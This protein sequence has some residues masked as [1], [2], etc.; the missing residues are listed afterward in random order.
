MAP[1]PGDSAKGMAGS[2]AQPPIA[3]RTDFNPLAT[4]AAEVR[5]GA[6]GTAQVAIE[7]PDNLT[8]YR[9]MVVAVSGGT[10]FGTAEANLVARLPLMVRPSAPRFLN[11]GD[12]FEFPVVLQNQT[13]EPMAVDVALR[14]TNL[15]L[16][17]QPGPAPHRPRPRPARGALPSDHPQGRHGP[18]PG[19]RRLGRLCRR[20]IRRVPRLHPGHDRGLCHLRRRRRG[21]RRP[22]RGGR[23]RFRL[24]AVRRPGDYHL[25]HRAPGPHRRRPLP[26][27][28]PLRVLRAV[29]V[30][31]PGRLGPA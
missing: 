26:R 4:F 20:G 24:L 28:L 13:D 3:V 21:R 2:E 11:F 1:A 16:D 7:L 14:V 10:H 29:G 19:S 18:L 23:R 22:A 17:R 9:V 27:L 6:G 12:R 15:A 8:R 31:H 5:T 30:A 25:F